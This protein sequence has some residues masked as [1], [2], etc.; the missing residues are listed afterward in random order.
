MPVTGWPAFTAVGKFA[1]TAAS[2]AG[3]TLVAALELDEAL[4]LI[5]VAGAVIEATLT[6][7]LLPAV[8]LTTNVAELPLGNVGTAIPGP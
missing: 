2:G 5:T 1:V 3:V 7:L 8:P 6:I 4:V